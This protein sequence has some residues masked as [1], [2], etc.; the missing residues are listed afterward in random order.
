MSADREKDRLPF[1][2]KS[3]RTKEQKTTANASQAASSSQSSPAAKVQPSSSTRRYS[4]DETS[5][6]EAVSRRMFKR[7]IFFSGI[8]VSLGLLIFFAS[9][10]IIIQGIAE[11]PNIAVLLT[12][13]LCF[14]LSV[15]GLSYGALSASWEE[16]ATGTL[17]GTEQFQVNFE[18][19]MG[20]WRQARDERRKNARGES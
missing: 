8:P 10:V 19:L 2:P 13:L 5:I 12:T 20:S 17:L 3:K 7:M 14:G 16:D 4:R 18:R 1:E 6:P 9:Y 11:L 15:V